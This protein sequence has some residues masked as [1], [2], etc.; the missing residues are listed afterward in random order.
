MDDRFSNIFG[1]TLS[2]HFNV[3]QDLTFAHSL[4][5]KRIADD[6]FTNI[7][8][9]WTWHNGSVIPGGVLMSECAVAAYH[10]V[11]DDFV[12]DSLQAQFLGGP[13]AELPMLFKVTR[14]S[15]G[16]RFAVRSVAIEQEGVTMLH[17]SITFVNKAPWTGPAMNYSVHRR[18]NHSINE[19]TIDDL[20]RGRTRLG[21][22]MKFQRLPLVYKGQ[23]SSLW[24][25]DRH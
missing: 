13:K 15:N 14:L 25:N 3:M 10:T 1:I 9:P 6:T 17:A 18:T 19:I 24:R 4:S 2:R 16:R 7:H 22:F 12:L 8:Q 5:L 20:G 21:P 23:C 11:P